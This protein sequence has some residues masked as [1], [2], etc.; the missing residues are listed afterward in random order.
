MSKKRQKRQNQHQPKADLDVVVPVYGLPGELEGCLLSLFQTREDLRIMVYLVD[1]FSPDADEMAPVYHKLKG[2]AV[3]VH[4]HNQNLGFPA[5]VNQGVNLGRAPLILILN[6]DV[7]F[8]AGCIQAMVDEF[9]DDT[10]GIV[11]PKL[12]FPEDST[13]VARPAGRVQHVGMAA[14]FSGEFF[15]PLIGWSAD[16]PKTNIRR[17]VQAVTGACMVTR[18]SLWREVTHFYQEQSPDKAQI[19]GAF[20]LLYGHGTYEDL[21]YCFIARTKGH[22]VIVTPEAVGTHRVGASAVAANKVYPLA[23]NK[24]IFRARCGGLIQWDEYKFY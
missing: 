21:E 5:T 24:M 1:D 15:H 22:K 13:D 19:T 20:C 14:D 6:T 9:K 10:V 3:R 17:E 4:R 2:P 16:N 7:R 11:A 18:R 8:H 23:R 12:L